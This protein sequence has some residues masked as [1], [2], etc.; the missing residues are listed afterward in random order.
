[1][2]QFSLYVTG[3]LKPG[4]YLRVTSVLIILF[5]SASTQAQ[6]LVPEL[7]F[8]N[9]QLKTGMGCSGDGQ[10]G[11]VYI[12]ENVGWGVDALVTI[13]GR[14]SKAVTLSDIDIQGPDQN[15][16]SGTGYDN[17]WQPRI[18]Y[19]GGKAPAHLIWWME[20]KISFVKHSNREESVSVNLFNVL[21]MDIDGDGDQLHEFQVYYNM[22]SFSL[23]QKT[24]IFTASVRGSESNPRLRGKRFDGT[25]K[26]YPGISVVE[27]EAMVSNYY[28][29]S[30]SMT[31]RL[32]AETGNS[33]T[34]AADR[35]YGLLFKSLV[36]DVP[37]IKKVTVNQV[38]T[39]KSTLTKEIE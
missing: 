26:N 13:L 9:P 18:N 19:A 4:F 1:M 25:N 7:I 16:V 23:D 8:K 15:A 37:D 33:G 24:A 11:S 6:S 36:Y 28:A 3:H 32:G 22:H 39:N 12:F 34:M 2:K 27:A 20:F 17:S 30:S 38:A 35:M 29:G 14:S 5:I 10:D 31:V 21:G